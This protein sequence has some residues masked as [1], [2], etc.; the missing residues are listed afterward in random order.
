MAYDIKIYGE[1][2]RH[3]SNTP[4]Y[5]TSA[6]KGI[7]GKDGQNGTSMY[8]VNYDI[9]ND[10]YKDVIIKKINNNIM[11]SSDAD[12]KQEGRA[13]IDGDLILSSDKTIYRIIKDNDIYDIETIGKLQ[14]DNII[15]NFK[16][17]IINVHINVEYGSDFIG[18]P[19]TRSY[20]T[21]SRNSC[22][23]KISPKIFTT[24]STGYTYFLK[25]YLYN[26]KYM[27]Y[28][29]YALKKGLSDT[30][31]LNVPY[32]LSLSNNSMEFFKKIEIP[33]FEWY[34]T[35]TPYDASTYDM[36]IPDIV[37]DLLH[38]S[39]NNISVQHTSN[40]YNIDVSNGEYIVSN[41]VDFTLTNNNK[42]EDFHTN[43]QLSKRKLYNN[44]VVYNYRSGES[45]YFSGI[46]SDENISLADYEKESTSL[47]YTNIV[48]N[49]MYNF[50]TSEKNKFELVCVNNISH[51]VEIVDLKNSNIKLKFV[52]R[53]EQ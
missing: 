50:L 41:N 13:Y 38:P 6:T 26:K 18:C 32:D 43:I 47:T 30:E 27:C 2:I 4:S 22:Y 42:P 3:T 34:N 51:K 19:D 45:C 39:G 52:N 44:K 24:K 8:L 48:W 15:N 7:D 25:I 36:K 11:L 10:F 29:D 9:S 28:E 14:D 31:S 40:G 49:E 1:D 12:I 20:E 17:D 35:E 5:I 33:L 21:N 37:F 16:D 23:L 53:N 46:L